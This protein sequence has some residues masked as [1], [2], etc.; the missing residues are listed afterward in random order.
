MQALIVLLVIAVLLLIGPFVVQFGWGLFMVPVFELR[1]ITF[2]EAIGFIILACFFR[3]I[4]R[5]GN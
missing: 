1:N 5:S 3:G 4:S 2:V